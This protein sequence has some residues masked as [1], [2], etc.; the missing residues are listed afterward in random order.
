MNIT[1]AVDEKIA[2]EAREAARSMGKSLNQVV[3]EHLEALAGSERTRLEVQEL[4]DTAGTGDSRGHR[5]GRDAAYE[6]RLDDLVRP[7]TR[8]TGGRV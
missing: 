8:E 5:F 2:R 6:D 4:R 3:R 7:P 1:L